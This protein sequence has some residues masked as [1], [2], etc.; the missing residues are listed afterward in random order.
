MKIFVVV[1]LCLLGFS[2]TFQ[3][4]GQVKPGRLLTNQQ[5]SDLVDSVS[6][7]LKKHYIF[8]DKA[9]AMVKYMKAQL[10]KG[11]YKKLVNPQ[12][13]AQQIHNDIRGIHYDA[14]LHIA[15]EP[16]M[17]A[18]KAL[19]PEQLARA[20]KEELSAEKENNFNLQKVEVLPGNIGYFRFNGFTSQTAAAQAT[21]NAALTFLSNTKVLMIDLRFNGGGSATAPL[22]SYFFKDK[23]HLFDNVNTFSKDTLSFYTDPSSTTGLVLTMPVYI[24]TSKNT[25]SAAEA[26]SASM[27][28][29]KRATI[30]GDTTLGVS[31]QTGFF[32]LGNGFLAKIPFARPVSTSVFKDWEGTGVIPDVVITEEK[33]LVGAQEIVYRD[34]M[35]KAATD[36]EKKAIQW[37]INDLKASADLPNPEPGVLNNYAGTY[38]GGINFFVEGGGLRC[39]NPERGG[40]DVFKLKPVTDHVFVL[41][42][43]VQVEFVKDLSGNYSSMNMLW[44]NGN[45]IQRNKE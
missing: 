13:L 40:N 38:A 2:L 41:D 11:V 33:G 42:E 31:H 22:S 16:Q 34:L 15:Y 45:I 24:I 14:H 32:P 35:Q 12:Q 19:S 30:V 27:Q 10:Q 37:A 28:A 20:R 6:A 21:L 26:F 17:Q 1:L 18:P 8:P 25:A 44:K 43:N 23:T 36:K 39:K 5:I 7:S 3:G 9:D 4:Y 29:L